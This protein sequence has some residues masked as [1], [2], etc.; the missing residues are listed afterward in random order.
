MSG[1][2]LRVAEATGGDADLL[3]RL[4]ELYAY[5]FSDLLELDLSPAGRYI[6][7]GYRQG[8]DAVR[9]WLLHANGHPAG[10]AIA[11]PGSVIDDCSDVW[12]MREFFVVRRYRR[13]GAGSHLALTVW[14]DQPGTWDIRVIESNRPVLAFWERTV[15]RAGGRILTSRLALNTRNGK[16][17]HV[18]R[19]ETQ[20]HRVRP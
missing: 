12:D 6:P 18:L 9:S 7:A 10:F 19:F 2:D 8:G 3:D 5:D 1:L 17:E 11:S 20:P 15:A 14:R 16:R 13:I 4:F